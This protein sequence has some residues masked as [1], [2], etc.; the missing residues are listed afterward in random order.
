MSELDNLII[1]EHDMLSHSKL[2]WDRFSQDIFDILKEK[3]SDDEYLMVEPIISGCLND[4]EDF[5]FTQ[6]FIR[7][8]AAVKGGAI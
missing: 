1:D 5:A 2:T 7:G 6:G 8:I 4:I 3:F